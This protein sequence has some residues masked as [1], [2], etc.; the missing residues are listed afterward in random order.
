M[1]ANELRESPPRDSSPRLTIAERI[2][3]ANRA[4]QSPCKSPLSAVTPK[5][6]AAPGEALPDQGNP[7]LASSIRTGVVSAAFVTFARF[8][9]H[10]ILPVQFREFGQS[11]ACPV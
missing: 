5:T 7:G 10:P 8:F 4:P 11:L 2:C 9:A 3:K 6:R 1:Q